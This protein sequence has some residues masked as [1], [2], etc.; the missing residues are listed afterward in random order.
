[1]SEEVKTP[2]VSQM[3]YLLIK[4][5]KNKVRT[6][7]TMT[8]IP[9]DIAQGRYTLKKDE[10]RIVIE[11]IA[12]TEKTK[13][14]QIVKVNGVSYI[15]EK[16]AKGKLTLTPAPEIK[17]FDIGVNKAKK[18]DLRVLCQSARLFIEE[19]EDKG[20]YG[21]FNESGNLLVERLK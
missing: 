14:V 7:N 9:T 13:K 3:L 19:R 4:D 5:Q 17:A 1:M 11:K 20:I 12:G 15:A 18:I 2:T 16:G 10:Q 21:V 6:W 8:T